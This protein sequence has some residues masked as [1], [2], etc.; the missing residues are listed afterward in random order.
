M[1]RRT[2]KDLLPHHAR[3]KAGQY[4]ACL[5]RLPPPPASC[6]RRRRLLSAAAVAAYF[7]GRRRRLLLPA[8][9][10]LLRGE[11]QH[12]ARSDIVKREAVVVL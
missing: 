4:C 9:A 1:G 6:D 8:A 5:L 10:A 11:H 3:P 2:Q 7:C 12:D